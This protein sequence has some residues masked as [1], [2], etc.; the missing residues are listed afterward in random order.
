MLMVSVRKEFWSS[1]ELSDTDEIRDVDLT[2]DSLG[3]LV[4]DASFLSKINGKNILILVHGYNNEEDDVVRS[5]NAIERKM[6]YHKLYGTNG[7]YDII[8]GYTWPGG[9]MALSYPAAKSRSGAVGPR[10]GRLLKKVLSSANSVDINT[11]SLGARVALI[12]LELLPADKSIQNLFMS[13]A[14]IDNELIQSGEKYYISV[15]SCS[16]VYVFHSK[17]DPVLKM[18]FPLGD[19][20]MA[21]G[22]SGPEDPGAIIKH[23]PNVKVINCKNIIKQHGAYKDCDQIYTYM[24]NPLPDQF[25]TL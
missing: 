3:I 17:N 5:Y 25:A 22:Y 23:S 2:D 6:R 24:L 13:A 16:N 9:D 19:F 21:L 18:M 20:D 7:K 15:D 8:I 4:N 14:A 10:F 1:T 11:H 12:G